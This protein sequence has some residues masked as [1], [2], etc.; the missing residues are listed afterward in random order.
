MIAVVGASGGGEGPLENKLSILEISRGNEALA[1]LS[2]QTEGQTY[3]PF[4][5]PSTPE[6]ATY[7]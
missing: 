3:S 7:Q 5:K 4:S 1:R 2:G 6:R